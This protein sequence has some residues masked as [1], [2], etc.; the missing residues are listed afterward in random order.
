MTRAAAHRRAFSAAGGVTALFGLWL[1]LEVG[2]PRSTL[3]F[4]DIAFL[5]IPGAVA[6]LLWRVRRRCA[7]SEKATWT[8]LSASMAAWVLGQGAWSYQ[9]L[10]QGVASP[11]PSVA[12]AGF[13]L[14]VPL[15]I[16]AILM[17][18]TGS[19]LRTYRLRLLV[20]GL[21]AANAL[22]TLSWVLVFEEQ[23]RIEA[24]WFERVVS[25]AYPLG[26][27]LVGA[28]ALLVLSR[29]RAGRHTLALLAAGLFLLAAAH[30]A[31]AYMQLHDTYVTGASTDTLWIAGFCLIGL[32]AHLHES[33]GSEETREAAP[34]SVADTLLVYAPV[35]VAITACVATGAF[36]APIDA[37]LVW[38]GVAAIVLIGVR[39]V[40]IL[41]ENVTLHRA[42]VASTA[43]FEAI[44]EHASDLVLLLDREGRFTYVSPSSKRL[45]GLLA[46]DFVGAK[47]RL[48]LHPEDLAA[49]TAAMETALARGAARVELRVIDG[50]GE[51]RWIEGI[52][53]DLSA[54]PEV[55]AIVVNARDVTERHRSETLVA[56]AASHD[57][58]TG[59]PLRSVLLARL[60][61]LDPSERCALLFCDVD[62]FKTVNDEL[63]HDAGDEVLRELARRLEAAVRPGDTVARFGGDEMVILA[64]AVAGRAAAHRL[65]ERVRAALAVPV[66][67]DGAAR[68]VSMSVGVAV[69]P[70]SDGRRLLAQADAAMYDAKRAHAGLVRFAHRPHPVVHVDGTVDTECAVPAAFGSAS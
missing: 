26:D 42:I 30:T 55:G 70:A 41:V 21:I 35:A 37:F 57:A 60:D 44:M 24:A 4:D 51:A 13:L 18:P 7:A 33:P 49:A 17:F 38:S 61:D 64:P 58:L 47:A 34:P 9:E 43:R 67:V 68:A 28:T 10:V 65:A 20:D 19:P 23:L 27:V 39:Q 69:G 54:N 46:G 32:A 15:S 53:T 52:F 5:I 25:L 8:L 31:F 22:L 12:D 36:R 2:G 50:G 62:R 1:S 56:Y 3:W 45:L 14:S 48:V 6:V 16:A 66:V 40:L 11:F 29:V 63:G 59:L